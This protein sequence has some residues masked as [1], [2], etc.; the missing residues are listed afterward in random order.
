MNLSMRSGSR[1]ALAVAMLVA[2]AGLLGCGGDT[3]GGE[4]LAKA[5]SVD[6]TYYYLPG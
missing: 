4:P 5:K 3:G 6:V 1:A 2:V